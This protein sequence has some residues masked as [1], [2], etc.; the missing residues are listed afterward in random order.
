MSTEVN[1]KTLINLVEAFGSQVAAPI[2]GSI[3]T[4]PATTGITDTTVRQP[5]DTANAILKAANPNRVGLTVFNNSPGGANMF[6]KLGA[7]AAIGAGSESYTRRL[8]PNQ[9][10]EIPSFYTGRVD[11]IWDAA[12]ANGE[13][14]LLERFTGFSPLTLS[15][16]QIWL[17]GEQRC[18]TG[19][20]AQD[21]VSHYRQQELIARPKSQRSSMATTSCVLVQ[22]RATR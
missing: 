7:T 3:T 20:T 12:D 11:A 6:V 14:V 19:S 15:G 21:C 13:A 4:V 1:G 8:A 2:T 5:V 17:R 18:P 22:V 9:Y 16:Y 10:W